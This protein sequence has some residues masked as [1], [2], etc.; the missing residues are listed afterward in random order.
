MRG[1]RV[2]PAALLGVLVAL[3]ACGTLEVGI[4]RTAAPATATPAAATPVVAVSAASPTGTAGLPPPATPAPGA[5]ATGAGR[6]TPS[7]RTR[8]TPG[9]WGTPLPP[10]ANGTLYDDPQGRFSFRVPQGWT[11]IPSPD[12]IS[13]TFAGPLTATALAPYLAVVLEDLAGMPNPTLE[14]YAQ[15]SA[16]VS[17]AS[18]RRAYPDYRLVSRDL[19]V[20]DNTLAYRQVSTVTRW[21]QLF[22]FVQIYFLDP[23]QQVAHVLTFACLAAQYAQQAATFDAIAGSYAARR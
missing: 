12:T 20:V 3:T 11:T 18:L 14:S 13:V 22:Q 16:E 10:L 1:R 17:E 4:E 21:G 9:T 23:Q 19:V 7:P 6:V 8:S 15:Q 5:P 2:W